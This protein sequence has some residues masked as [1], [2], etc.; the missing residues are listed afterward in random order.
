ALSSAI[1]R[2]LPTSR[3]STSSQQLV[4]SMRLSLTD[5]VFLRTTESSGS[6]R[7]NPSLSLR[8]VLSKLALS[9]REYLTSPIP[10]TPLLRRCWLILY[11]PVATI[12]SAG[13]SRYVLRQGP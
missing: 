10:L 9:K 11:L 4:N 12:K 2:E 3:S 13:L 5:T 6:R 7:V 1:V 8:L